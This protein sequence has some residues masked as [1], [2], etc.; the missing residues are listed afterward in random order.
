M[1]MEFPALDQVCAVANIR[2]QRLRLG[3]P[4][5]K[6]QSGLMRWEFF[7]DLIRSASIGLGLPAIKIRDGEWRAGFPAAEIRD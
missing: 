7:A 3:F 4:L 1:R 2:T 6:N 5:V